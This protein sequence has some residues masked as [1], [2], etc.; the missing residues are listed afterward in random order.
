[1]FSPPTFV[2][3]TKLIYNRL[4]QLQPLNGAAGGCGAVSLCPTLYTSSVA[5]P[6]LPGTNGSLVYPGYNEFSPGNAI[7]FGGPQNLY[8]IF[9]DLNWTKGK[10]RSNSAVATF[11]PATTGIFGAYENAVESL[12]PADI[13]TSL[14]N[15]LAGQLYQFQ[16]ATYPQGKYP[17]SKER[18]WALCYYSGLYFSAARDG[19]VVRPQQPLQ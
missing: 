7:P 19:T 8:Q 14:A 12:G 6:T 18:E 13:P 4:N 3:S 5:V 9:E 11:R 16:G 10:H 1:M 15:L 2:S 17:C